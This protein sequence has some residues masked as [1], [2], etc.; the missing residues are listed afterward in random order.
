M[1]P[2]PSRIPFRA[3]SKANIPSVLFM[4][5]VLVFPSYTATAQ[6]FAVFLTANPSRFVQTGQDVTLSVDERVSGDYALA[7]VRLHNDSFFTMPMSGDSVTVAASVAASG[8][9]SGAKVAVRV[10]AVENDCL[11]LSAAR[12]PYCAAES[13]KITLIWGDYDSEG[14]P[15]VDVETAFNK[16]HGGPLVAVVILSVVIG[17]AVLIFFGPA[18]ACGAFLLSLI[19]MIVAT[20]AEINPVIWIFLVLAALGGVS[21]AVA[22][23][24]IKRR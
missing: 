9:D 11:S 24:Y 10:Y 5:A 1:T 4:I 23:G 20:P 17:I 8:A 21:L 12:Q 22:S 7:A 13:N 19:V 18:A 14:R 3:R 16:V 6:E 2:T 15:Q